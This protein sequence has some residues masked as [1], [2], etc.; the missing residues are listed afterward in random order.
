LL[1]FECADRIFEDLIKDFENIIIKEDL[2][3]NILSKNEQRIYLECE[4]PL[5]WCQANKFKRAKRKEQFK[6]LNLAYA[7]TNYKAEI[8]DLLI[9][10][11]AE[12]SNVES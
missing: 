3:T 10:K 12:L 1:N 11:Y 4:N 2:N 9:N 6:A 7:A 5:H 8:L